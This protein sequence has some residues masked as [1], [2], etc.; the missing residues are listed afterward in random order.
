M[1]DNTN[2]QQITLYSESHETFLFSKEYQTLYGIGVKAYF[3]GDVID[4]FA[5]VQE[6]EWQNS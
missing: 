6:H 4:V 1:V 5:A 3:D 2:E